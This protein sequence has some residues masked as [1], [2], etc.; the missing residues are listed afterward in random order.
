[1]TYREVAKFAGNTNAYRAVGTIL[2]SNPDSK[3]IPCHRVVRSN[4]TLSK[5]YAFGGKAA[6][7]KKLI[8]EGINFTG[9]TISKS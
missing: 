1:M 3:K 9:N 2:H 4:M 7:K 5:G 6:Q 8:D